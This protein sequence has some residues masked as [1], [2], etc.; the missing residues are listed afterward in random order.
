MDLNAKVVVAGFDYTYGKRDIA[1]MELL[2]KYA[3]NRFEIITVDEQKNASGKISST[4]VRDL[5]LQGDIEQ[6]KR[7]VRIRLYHGRSRCSRFWTR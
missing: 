1:N 2:P 3:S 5:L 4:A 7:L 6:A